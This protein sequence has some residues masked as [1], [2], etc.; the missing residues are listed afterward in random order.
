MLGHKA[1]FNKYKKTEVIPYVFFECN[2]LQ[3]KIT[4]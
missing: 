3:I 4:N 1:C 2:E